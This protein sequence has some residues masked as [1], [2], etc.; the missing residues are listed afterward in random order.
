M[1]MLYHILH[2]LIV[3]FAYVDL[4]SNFTNGKNV[5]DVNSKMLSH[6]HSTLMYIVVTFMLMHSLH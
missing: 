2:Q 4:F 3:S 6:V 1:W 5:F